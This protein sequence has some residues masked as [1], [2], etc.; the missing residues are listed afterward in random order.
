MNT[1]GCYFSAVGEAA[2]EWGTDGE[3]WMK[4]LMQARL[5]CSAWTDSAP[6]V[7]EPMHDKA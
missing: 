2:D 7:A 1:I 6:F 4:E 3:A 5:Q